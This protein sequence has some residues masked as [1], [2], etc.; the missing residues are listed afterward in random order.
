MDKDSDGKLSKSEVSSSPM[1]SRM[2]S[3]D[4]DGDEQITLE[5]FRAG[6]SSMFRGGGG[7]GGYRGGGEDNR[8]KRPQRPKMDS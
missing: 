2:G 4:K 5:E 3:M 6:L 1:G 8:P 7:R